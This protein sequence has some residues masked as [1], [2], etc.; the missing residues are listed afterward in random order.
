MKKGERRQDGE[1][2]KVRKSGEKRE[3]DLKEEK[4][5]VATKNMAEKQRDKGR[6]Q[7]VKRPN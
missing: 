7:K 1:K 4:K 6:W 2:S 3:E 5:T